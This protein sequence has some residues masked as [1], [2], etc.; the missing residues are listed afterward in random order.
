MTESAAGYGESA[1]AVSLAK[2]L[3]DT[4]FERTSNLP[5]GWV[6]GASL[7]SP[8]VV[9]VR[10]AGDV[11]QLAIDDVSVLAP[12][13]QAIGF[14]PVGFA[15]VPASTDG[16]RDSGGAHRL[17]SAGSMPMAEVTGLP[18]L[19]EAL[20]AAFRATRGA[21]LLPPAQ[22]FQIATAK[23]PQNTEAERLVVQR[24]G[25]DLFRKALLKKWGGRCPITGIDVPELLR[26]S[27]I[28]PWAECGSDEERLDPENGLLIAVQWD[29]AFDQGFVSFDDA[30]GVI[31]SPDLPESARLSLGLRSDA[32]VPVSEQ[33]RQY[34]SWHRDRVLRPKGE[35]SSI[36]TTA[37]TE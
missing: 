13:M 23:L 32:V 14:S 15:S 20:V 10:W 31:W 33:T 5:E 26:A 36:G 19:H 24:V 27:H 9:Y 6:C 3:S 16:V 2:T 29:A 22:A 12:V 28:K 4:G 8:L 34:L 21:G 25:Q 30:G 37:T 1:R 18:E 17:A 35:H 7:T 11:I